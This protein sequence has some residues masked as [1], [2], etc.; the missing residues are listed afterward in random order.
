MHTH[1][2]LC[3]EMLWA[4]H[5]ARSRNDVD[6]ASY[7]LNGLTRVLTM[8]EARGLLLYLPHLQLQCVSCCLLVVC[9]AV[10]LALAGFEWQVVL[11]LSL[12]AGVLLYWLNGIKLN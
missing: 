5:C 11:F 6:G 8:T 12:L 4:A 3:K 1:A 2:Q 10:I 7:I 9:A